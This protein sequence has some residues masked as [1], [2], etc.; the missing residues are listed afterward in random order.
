MRFRRFTDAGVEEFSQYIH[1]LRNDPKLPVPSA[2]IADDAL[3]ELLTPEVSA[4]PERF[5][6]RM[7]FAR[8]LDRAFEESDAE[9]PSLDT[10]FWTWLAAVL[11]DQLCPADGHGRRKPGAD[12]RYIPDMSRW[13]RR[14]RHLLANPYQ[15][16]QLHR[17]DPER[18]AVALVN[19]LHKPGEL[20]EQFTARLEIIRCPGTIG[21]ATKLFIDP[22]TGA[23]RH[24]ASGNAARRFGKLMNQY[25]RTWDLQSVEADTFVQLLPREFNRFKP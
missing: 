25:T 4:T 18:A 10:G 22:K 12:A 16:L 11:F 5:S 23:R 24:G 19:P 6:T 20:T 21:L 9:V 15:V 7:E 8:W 2:L 13:T 17:D 1:A 3:T 14:Y